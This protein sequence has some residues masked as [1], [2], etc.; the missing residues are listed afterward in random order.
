VS[1]EPTVASL[2]VTVAEL[3]VMVA[4]LQATVVELREQLVGRDVRIAELEKLLS[5]SRRGGKR[6]A[7]P[8]SKGDPVIEPQRSGRKR[9]KAYGRHGHRLAPSQADRTL[10]ALLPSSCPC[11]GGEIDVEREAEQWQTELVPVRAV[12]TRFRVPIGRCR[13]CGRRVQAHHREQTSDALGAAGAQIGPHAKAWAAWLHYGLGLSF[14]KCQAVLAH[15]G[16]NVTAGALCT[17]A[18]ATGCALEP[19]HNDLVRRVNTASA[20]TMDETGWRVGGQGAWLW[21]ATTDEVTVYRVA[22]TRGFDSATTLVDADYTGTIIRDGWAPYRRYTNAQHQTCAAHILRRCGELDTDLPAW[23]RSTP[24]V[25][26]DIVHSALD[27][28]DLPEP[29]RQRVA[30]DLTER[31]ELLAAQAHSHDECRKLVAHV[32]RETE[33]LFTFLTTPGVEATNWR[34]EQAIRPAVVNRKVWG[35]N[36]TPRGAITQGRIM[37][38]L[39][40][41]RQLGVDG[42]D[43]LTRYARAP[44]T[45]NLFT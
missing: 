40:T 45:A 26:A 13:R 14:A 18:Q 17:A 19:V 11:C 30:T 44:T 31:V 35:G 12:T 15:L 20:V 2:L 32:A 16:I 37:S 43:Y 5:E 3:Q 33:A 22:D 41:A 25:V 34:A 28:R 36:R 21:V 9:G 42:I 29:E 27:A 24:R 4:Q 7:A 10:D 39:V 1:C 8:F 23:A 38:V 6:Q